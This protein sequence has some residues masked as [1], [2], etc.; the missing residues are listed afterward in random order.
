MQRLFISAALL[1]AFA[2]AGQ[3]FPGDGV[4]RLSAQPAVDTTITIRST[5]STLEFDPP[6]LSVK[7]GKRVRLRY[8]NDGTLP[9]NIVL[10]RNADD[11][12]E[13]AVAAYQAGETGYVPLNDKEKLIAWSTLASP[14]QTVEVIFVM[15]PPG[16]YTYVCL[17]PGHSSS[18]FGTLRSLR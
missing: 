8:V 5:G 18:M 3:R 1:V 7:N 9:H 12:D 17:F 6:R 10:P 15:P 16:E 2:V 11:I 14:G 4:P 13:L